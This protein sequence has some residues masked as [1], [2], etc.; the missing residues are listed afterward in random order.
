MHLLFI[1]LCK[2][3]TLQ[4]TGIYQ[5]LLR[6][7]HQMGHR[8]SVV[9]PSEKRLKIPTKCYEENG[10]HFLNVQIGNI[11]KTNMI[12]K[13][14]S[15][16]QIESQFKKA[17]KQ[18]FS[19]VKFDVIMYSTP[20]ITFASVIE[21]IKKRDGAKSY[22]LLKDIFPQNAVDLGI[23]SKKS[24]LNY[25]FR[26]K[27]HKLYQLS[28]YIGCMSQANVDFIVNNNPDIDK[29]IVHVSPNSIEICDKNIS[30]ERKAFL[31]KKYHV[32]LDK[33]VF[34][35]GGNLGRPQGIP[36]LID[37]LKATSDR[38]DCFFVICGT[39]TE[40]GKLELYYNSV[41]PSHVLLINGLPKE[42]YEDFISACDVGLI[43]LDHRFTIPNFPSR[44]LSY[45][46]NSM[47]VIA[48]TD[49]NTDIGQV[50]VDGGF[51]WWCESNDVEA[52]TKIVNEASLID[53]ADKGENTWR[54]LHENY[55]VNISY[56]IMMRWIE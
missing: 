9:S 18:H 21:Y 43:F 31:R 34:I 45:M 48:A 10:V 17:I 19:D 53:L 4:T 49:P 7:F 1:T 42:E 38:D 5:D 50:I 25:F 16:L 46:N 13:G 37:C 51:G 22:L 15:T 56:Q 29:N 28:D 47:P 32:P 6:K 44:L 33:K 54:Y 55:T 26:K 8:I 23:F 27:E 20:P 11:T 41:K 24:L 35:Y 30:A 40:Y 39:G 3:S 36:F 52:F 12:E 2:I 14:I